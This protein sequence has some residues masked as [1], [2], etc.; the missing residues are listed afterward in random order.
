MDA[1]DLPAAD[2]DDVRDMDGY[3]LDAAFPGRVASPP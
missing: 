1:N 3:A 2:G